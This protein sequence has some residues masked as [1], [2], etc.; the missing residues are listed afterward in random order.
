MK[1]TDINGIVDGYIAMWNETDAAKR[2]ELIE[3]VWTDKAAYTDPLAAVEGREAISA[4]VEAVQ[5]QF[6]GYTFRLGGNIDAH[7]DVARFTWELA[8]GDGEALVI[9][10]D[11]AVCGED[12]RID[13]VLGFLDKVPAM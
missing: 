3:A 6:P 7:H 1:M 12:G 4:V 11:V 13:S 8:Q 2:A 5:G 10:F 9:G